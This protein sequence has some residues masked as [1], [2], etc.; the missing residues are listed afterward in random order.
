[1]G[2]PV[3]DL[4]GQVFGRL[5]VLRQDGSIRKH[6]AWSCLCSCGATTRVAS[7]SLRSKDGTRSCGCLAAEVHSAGLIDRNTSHG[8]SRSRVYRIYKE[9]LRRCTNPAH[10]H[11]AHYGGRGIAVCAHWSGPG[12]F[13]NFLSDMGEPAPGQSI[14]RWPNNDGGY[15]PGNCRWATRKEQ[16]SNTS[17]SRRF[18]VDGEALTAAE[19][20]ERA[21]VKENTMRWRLARWEPEKA[22]HFTAS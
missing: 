6:A 16:A 7:G 22:L 2:R 12:G 5:R 3:L 13:E 10:M 15:E 17:R 9:M 4:T 18:V 19:M 11:F 1:M 21:G 8:M 14:D 20:A